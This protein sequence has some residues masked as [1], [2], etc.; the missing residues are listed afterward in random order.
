MLAFVGIGDDGAVKPDQ[1]ALQL[2]TLRERTARDMVATLR[3][4]AEIGYR[5]VELAGY[6]GLTAPD[7]RATLDG[8]G[9]RAMGAHV[10]FDRFTLQFDQVLDELQG[11]GCDYAVLPS[12]PLEHRTG[13]R[14]RDLNATLNGWGERCRAAGLTFAYHNH[15]FE[16]TRR[17]ADGGET[18]FDG[19]VA[20]TDPALV[21]FELDIYWVR[22]SGIDPITLLQRDPLRFPLLH[23]KDMSGDA[24]RADLPVGAGI[25]DWRAGF[26]A[27]SAARWYIVEQDH[28]ADAL[29]D[30]AA[31]L[32]HLR[33][34][35]G[36]PSTTG[37][38]ADNHS[39]DASGE[40]QA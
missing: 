34:L 33:R 3:D 22:Y 26:G 12:V 9:L 5:T 10:A 40:R 23:I 1:I 32:D 13:L 37:H 4:L 39:S 21:A 20:D 2:Y 17:S 24:D 8:L 16:F 27:A 25:I 7:L 29:R 19:L 36:A 31:S 14:V 6:G 30:V 38:D 11:L 18:M 28:P 15:A 35:A